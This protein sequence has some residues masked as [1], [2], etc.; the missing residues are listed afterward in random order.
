MYNITEV[1]TTTR[2]TVAKLYIEEEYRNTTARILRGFS[3][4]TMAF[5]E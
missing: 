2:K 1:L 5:I 4:N 3:H